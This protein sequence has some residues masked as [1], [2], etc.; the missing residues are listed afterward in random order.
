MVT[1]NR[2]RKGSWKLRTLLGELLTKYE[3]SVGQILAS[4]LGHKDLNTA[5]SVETFQKKVLNSASKWAIKKN[6]VV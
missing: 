2:T 1:Y 6:M 3:I 5:Y 4:L